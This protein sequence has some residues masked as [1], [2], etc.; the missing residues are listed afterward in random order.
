MHDIRLFFSVFRL[1]DV[2]LCL[3][4]NPYWIKYLYFI[5]VHLPLHTRSRQL[6]VK[7][8]C[9]ITVGKHSW[10]FFTASGTRISSPAKSSERCSSVP[11]IWFLYGNNFDQWHWIRWGQYWFC[12][13][14]GGIKGFFVSQIIPV[15]R[16]MQQSLCST[17][18]CWCAVG[19]LPRA[20]VGWCRRKP[21]WLLMVG[22]LEACNWKYKGC[23]L[24]PWTSVEVWDSL[25]C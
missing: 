6:C 3:V 13:D 20:K 7:E 18:C 22:K 2:L 10:I 5:Y 11:L 23:G 19:R 8:W 1:L 17:H 4:S 9:I 25:G 24:F 21:V 12:S 15:T 16:I 14:T